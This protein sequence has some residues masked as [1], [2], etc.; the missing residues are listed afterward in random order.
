MF[1]I[2]SSFISVFVAL[3]KNGSL[4]DSLGVTKVIAVPVFQALHVLHTLCMYAS[5]F[6][7]KE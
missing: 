1:G 7:G 2:F 4:L 3:L 5:G 6:W